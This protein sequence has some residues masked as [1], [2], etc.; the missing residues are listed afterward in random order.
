MTTP[1]P[2]AFAI[3]GVSTVYIDG[4]LI[5]PVGP[6]GAGVP[7][8]PSPVSQSSQDFWSTDLRPAGDPTWEQLSVSL[9]QPRLISYISLDLP[10]F[11]HRAVF[12]YWDGEAWAPA[13]RANGA[14]LEILTVGSVP[15]VVNNPAALGAGQNP[16]H[17]GAGHWVHH[18]EDI[19]AVTTIRLLVRLARLSQGSG[20]QKFPVNPYGQYAPYPL[21]VRN[22]DFGTRLRDCDDAPYALRD[23]EVLTLRQ[24]FITSTDVAGSPVQVV[25]R[26]NRACDLF[27]SE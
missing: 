20:T 19:A 27:R 17:Y 3:P 14:P 6:P 7:S 25:I 21:G 11:P 10:H 15:A 18:D 26:E 23:P 8:K 24:P 12:Y 2:G 9:A 5:E 1:L 13:A 22:L 4:V 16:Y